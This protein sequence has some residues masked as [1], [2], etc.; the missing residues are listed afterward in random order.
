[1]SYGNSVVMVGNEWN[2]KA[3]IPSGART[4][5]QFMSSWVRARFDAHCRRARAAGAE[6]LRYLRCSF[7]VTAAIVPETLR[8]T[9]GLSAHCHC[10]KKDACGVGR[11]KRLHDQATVGL[12]GPAATECPVMAQTADVSKLRLGDATFPM[13]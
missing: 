1:M 5:S 4:P 6:S 3:Q 7:M 11:G 2:T 9:F 10:Q 13:S 8:A 12:I